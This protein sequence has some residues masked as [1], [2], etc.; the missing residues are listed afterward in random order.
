MCSLTI[1]CGGTNSQVLRFWAAHLQRCLAFVMATHSRLGEGCLCGEL[2]VG[3]FQMILSLPSQCPET[4][5]AI[6]GEEEEEDEPTG[7]ETSDEES[8]DENTQDAADVEEEDG[9]AVGEMAEGGDS[10]VGEG[11]VQVVEEVAD[12]C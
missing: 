8:D 3:L 2:D 4:I 12:A 5:D 7:A 11:G 10:G 1:E 9:E 6:G